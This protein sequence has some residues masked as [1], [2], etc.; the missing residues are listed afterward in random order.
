MS[1][2]TGSLTSWREDEIASLACGVVAETTDETNLEKFSHRIDKRRNVLFLL[3]VQHLG[4]GK[5]LSR[6]DLTSEDVGEEGHVG[7]SVAALDFGWF[8]LSRC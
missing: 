7:F 6:L 3:C 8:G 1:F 5:N 2:L 4:V